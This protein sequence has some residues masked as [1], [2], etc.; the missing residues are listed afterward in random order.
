MTINRKGEIQI[1]LNR[2]ELCGEIITELN[3]KTLNKEIGWKAYT[4]VREDSNE[5]ALF[6]EL[7]PR[8]FTIKEE[9]IKS[10]I[11]TD[12]EHLSITD[13]YFYREQYKSDRFIIISLLYFRFEEDDKCNIKVICHREH[14]SNVEL[15]ADSDDD[16]N[17][18]VLYESVRLK[19]CKELNIL[20][21]LLLSNNEEQG[22]TDNLDKDQDN[23]DK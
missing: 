16:D 1:F 4:E 14:K 10:N 11:V 5:L 18:K 21:K 19:K 12:I 17:V 2:S 22:S 9:L 20:E 15:I 8:R 3:R 23:N 6:G 13:S 7:Y